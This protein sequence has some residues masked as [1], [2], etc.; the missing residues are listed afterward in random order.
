MT[1]QNLD[2]HTMGARLKMVD[3][4]LV[5]MLAARHRLSLQISGIKRAAG[6]PIYRHDIE[7]RRIESTRRYGESLG[8]NPEFVAGIM[9]SLIRESCM[10]QVIDRE[11]NPGAAA[12]VEPYETQKANLL[13]LTELIASSYDVT[14]HSSHATRLYE[15]YEDAQ[16]E[17]LVQGMSREQRRRFLDLG[18]G[19]GKIAFRA[20]YLFGS[21][22]GYDL[23]P[24]M[25]E[26]ARGKHANLHQNTNVNFVEADLESGI[27]EADGS[28]SFVAMSL[29]T[30]SDIKNIAHV[31]AE[32]ARVLE[33]GGRFMFS[34]YNAGALL[35]QWQYLPW[36]I[37]LAARMNLDDHCLDVYH[38]GK[39]FQVYARPYTTDEVKKMF[40]WS[41][42]KVVTYPTISSIIPNE[43]F[44]GQS[45]DQVVEAVTALDRQLSFGHH[46]AYIIVSGVK[47]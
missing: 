21:V 22:V 33:Q 5:Q 6:E 4:V 14:Y 36:Q 19:T 26:V 31:I 12:S 10:D 43:A 32:T 46:G 15:R 3:E 27:P 9:Y 29:G 45:S 24:H 38:S 44:I 16:L 18:C 35:Y 7:L 11:S 2:L 13:K 39:V 42:P 8:L 20:G 34:F 17:D 1:S 41:D 30:A 25:L 28:V 23:S 37:S 40:D 47:K